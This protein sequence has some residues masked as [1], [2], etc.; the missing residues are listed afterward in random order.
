MDKAMLKI[1]NEEA[2]FLRKLL[3]IRTDSLSIELRKKLSDFIKKE[4]QAINIANL[5]CMPSVIFR[6]WTEKFGLEVIH[7]FKAW[8]AEN[9]THSLNDDATYRFSIF[10]NIEDK[11]KFRIY[12][13]D[14]L[15]SERDVLYVVVFDKGAFVAKSIV[16]GHITEI[17]D[18]QI[19][20]NIF[21]NKEMIKK[22]IFG[23]HQ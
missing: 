21:E 15:E 6:V 16:T 14:L 7:D 9:D 3:D 5:Q 11:N 13:G 4:E 19:V 17:K 12:T 23:Q 2:I 22:E 18:M 8:F 1:N 10:T 20:G